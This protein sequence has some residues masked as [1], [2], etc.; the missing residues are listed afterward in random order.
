MQI[1]DRA[2]GDF[3]DIPD[4]FSPDET[5][6]LRYVYILKTMFYVSSYDLA[7]Q[8]NMLYKENREQSENKD[9]FP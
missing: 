8:K 2:L 6:R 5:S 3:L 4:T 1:S 9:S 7:N